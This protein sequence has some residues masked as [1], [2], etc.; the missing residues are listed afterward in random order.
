[1][2]ARANLLVMFLSGYFRMQF[3]KFTKSLQGIWFVNFQSYLK[4]L[5]DSSWN[6]TRVLLSEFEYKTSLPRLS[7]LCFF[8]GVSMDVRT[9][10]F[11]L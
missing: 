6:R 10:R 2:L 11:K 9:Q 4:D 8:H 1:V 3:E 7:A 5:V